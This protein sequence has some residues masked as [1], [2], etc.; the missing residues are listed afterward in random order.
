MMK[1]E[2]EKPNGFTELY[3]IKSLEN[4]MEYILE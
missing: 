2:N 1:D 3:G 4:I